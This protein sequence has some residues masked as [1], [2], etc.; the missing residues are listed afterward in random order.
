MNLDEQW[1]PTD[2]DTNRYFK[3]IANI[4]VEEL[5]ISLEEAASYI[6]KYYE[7]FTNPEF[8][9]S[10]NIPVQND[11][12]FWH[13]SERGMALRIVYYTVKEHDPDPR[14]FI[15]WRSGSRNA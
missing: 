12:F 4:L 5:N 14:A 13:E 8:C 6:M 9:K 3:D 10:I 1:L 15:E 11:D 7:N 2:E